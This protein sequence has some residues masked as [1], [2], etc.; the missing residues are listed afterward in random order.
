MSAVTMTPLE[1]LRRLVDVVRLLDASECGELYN[2][3]QG[4]L[5]V[6]GTVLADPTEDAPRLPS[7]ADEVIAFIGNNFVSQTTIGEDKTKWSYRLSVHD[8]LSAFEQLQ[9]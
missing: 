5:T 1:A 4:A 8:L 6:A 2:E 7:T 3:L 9:E